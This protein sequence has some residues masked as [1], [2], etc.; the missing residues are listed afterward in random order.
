MELQ[1]KKSFKFLDDIFKAVMFMGCISGVGVSLE[2][3]RCADLTATRIIFMTNCF[4][5]MRER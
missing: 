5:K 4:G 1:L 3:K 2:A